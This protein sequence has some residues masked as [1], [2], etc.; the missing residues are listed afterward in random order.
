MSEYTVTYNKGADV[1]QHVYHSQLNPNDF[2]KV[3]AEEWL[4]DGDDELTL[5]A[6]EPVA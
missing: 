5:E 6:R 2:Y 1:V 3:M 4:I